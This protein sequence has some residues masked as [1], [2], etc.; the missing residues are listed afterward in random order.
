[1]WVARRSVLYPPIKINA[2]YLIAVDQSRIQRFAV[3]LD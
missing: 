1:M 2:E 3:D